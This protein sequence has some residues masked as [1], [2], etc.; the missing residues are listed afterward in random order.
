MS[1][2]YSRE[3]DPVKKRVL[4]AHMQRLLGIQAKTTAIVDGASTIST[5]AASSGSGAASSSSGA[6]TSPLPANARPIWV[7]PD[8]IEPTTTREGY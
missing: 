2:Q 4:A 1:A 5:Q 7:D 8:I 6:T 3:A